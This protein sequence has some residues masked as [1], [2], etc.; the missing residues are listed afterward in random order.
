MRAVEH[1]RDG[2]LRCCSLIFVRVSKAAKCLHPDIP[3]AVLDREDQSGSPAKILWGERS[4]HDEQIETFKQSIPTD[5]AKILADRG[6]VDVGIPSTNGF[7]D[8]N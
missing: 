1:D 2:D 6:R 4:R 7:H 5:M 3:Y 8:E